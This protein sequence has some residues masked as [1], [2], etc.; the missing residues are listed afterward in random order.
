LAA[1]SHLWCSAD[2][3][4]AALV[5]ARRWERLVPP[6]APAWACLGS[7]KSDYVSQ[8][9]LRPD[10]RV[11]CGIH[12]SSANLYRYQ[13]AGLS[14][15]T[16]VSSGTWIVAISDRTGPDFD[17]EQPGL[18]CNADVNGRPLPGI[19]TM[20]GR[21]FSALA[22]ESQGPASAEQL[23]R[24]I[25]SDTMA[26]PSFGSD[27]SLF[28]GTAR[29][30]SVI[31]PL[32]QD[33]GARFTLAVLHTA[34]LTDRCL[35]AVNTATI[36]LDGSF[37]RDPLYGSIIAALNPDKRVVVNFDQY[38]TATGAALL[39]SHEARRKP[40]HMSL[41]PPR[42]LHNPGLFAYRARWREQAAS[43]RA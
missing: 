39:A 29:C 30:G 13:A 20:G 28:P 41:E 26:L 16:V 9:G 35:E 11:L 4:P 8:T 34:L 2:V 6:L 21:A 1:Q 42:P 22:G 7:L 32:A 27:D 14:D 37:V 15:M 40:A 33:A 5:A 31:G 23:E 38:G 10:I 19:L 36:V 25:A 17:V 43:R 12:D 24:V 18:C 3:K